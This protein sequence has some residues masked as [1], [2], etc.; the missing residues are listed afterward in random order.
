MSFTAP[1][2]GKRY[3][4]APPVPASTPCITWGYPEALGLC[5]AESTK[6]NPEEK[7]GRNPVQ[8]GKGRGGEDR[9]ALSEP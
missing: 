9:G 8:L 6:T 4:R 5:G 2:D 3:T 7:A 1:A